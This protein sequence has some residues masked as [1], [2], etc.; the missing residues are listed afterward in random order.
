MEVL[1]T[2]WQSMTLAQIIVYQSK[3]KA[4]VG[5]GYRPAGAGPGSTDDLEG[6]K[7]IVIVKMNRGQELRLRAIARKG[8]GKDHAKW[9]PV[10]T[11]AF[12]YMPDIR[13][14]LAWEG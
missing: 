14:E 6:D 1:L 3:Q 5:T 4:R 7:G 9:S 10:A 2:S 11:T 8:T 12:K 13:C